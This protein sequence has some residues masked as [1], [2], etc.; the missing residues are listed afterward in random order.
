M[1][2]NYLADPLYNIQ[3]QEINQS[4]YYKCEQFELDVNIFEQ[5]RK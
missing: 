3:T 4:V 1:I 5:V 2:K